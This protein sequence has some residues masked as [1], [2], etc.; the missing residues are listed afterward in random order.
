[1]ISAYKVST[2]TKR[3]ED[4]Y[5]AVWS[6]WVGRGSS[7]AASHC[8]AASNGNSASNS[9]LRAD[10]L[11]QPLTVLESCAA[12]HYKRLADTV[13]NQTMPL[14]GSDTLWLSGQ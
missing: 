5:H 4:I 2:N 9:H 8:K 10:P 6:W 13:E 14:E 12:F 3:R 1:M 11:I 7:K